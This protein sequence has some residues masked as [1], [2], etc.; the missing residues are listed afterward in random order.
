[1]A[2]LGLRGDNS[3]PPLPQ[4]PSPNPECVRCVSFWTWLGR[5]HSGLGG[6]GRCILQVSVP[7]DKGLGQRAMAGVGGSPQHRGY[8]APCRIHCAPYRGSPRDQHPRTP[9]P[10]QRALY[11]PQEERRLCLSSGPNILHGD[12]PVCTV[13]LKSNPNLPCQSDS[14]L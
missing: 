4:S 2:P 8:G 3:P 12:C 13:F 5:G 10:G 9:P 6:E 11:L 7:V 14:I 1:M